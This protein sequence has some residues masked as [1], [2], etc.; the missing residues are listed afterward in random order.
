MS[1]LGL[2]PGCAITYPTFIG[3]TLSAIYSVKLFQ[4]TDQMSLSK[5]CR[6]ELCLPDLASIA[7]LVGSALTA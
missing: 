2:N 3:I 4:T 5:G 1:R 6:S 7:R